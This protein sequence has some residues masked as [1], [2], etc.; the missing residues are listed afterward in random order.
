MRILFVGGGSG[1]HFYPLIAIA[2]NLREQDVIRGTVV[3][4]YYMGPSVFNQADLD[5]Y[6]IKFVYCPAGK[7]REYRSFQNY[8]DIFKIIYGAWVAFWKLYIIYPDVIMS[9]GGYTSVPIVFAAWLLKIPI[10]IHESDA[11]PGKANKFA[12]RFA[13]Y[14][15]VAHDDVVSFF[16]KNK[17]ALVGMPIRKTFFN[18]FSDPHSVVGVPNDRPVILVTG[19]SLGAKRINDFI[20]R[21]LPTLLSDF[22]VIHQ[23]GDNNVTEVTEAASTLLTNQALLERYFV[24]GHLTPEQFAAAQQAATLVITRAGSTTL[25]ELALLGKPAIIIPIP[26]DIS[27]DQRTN[28]YAYARSG[29]ATVIEEKNLSDDILIAEIR[30]IFGDSETYLAMSQAAK[31]FTTSDAAATLANALWSIG[32]SHQ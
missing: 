6:Q 8:L 30:R 23:T 3:D 16:P 14:I 24:L 28:A 5:Q 20:L 19:G 1:G 18:K 22:T 15:G 12:A 9:K 27:R 7:Q 32:E 13:K 25:F 21:S 26:E 11:V 17:V 4:L 10:V 29:G 2:E 31:S